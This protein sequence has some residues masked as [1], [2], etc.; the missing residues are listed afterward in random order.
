[1]LQRVGQRSIAIR[2]GLRAETPCS[3]ERRLAK[4][5]HV[6]QMCC[7]SDNLSIQGLRLRS[8]VLAKI[9]PL[10]FQYLPPNDLDSSVSSIRR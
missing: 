9:N 5:V 8:F 6:C 10:F 1:M 3:Q 7:G 4:N 2:L